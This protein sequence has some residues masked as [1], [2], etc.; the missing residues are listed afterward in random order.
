MSAQEEA[1]V[2]LREVIDAILSGSGQLEAQLRKCQFASQLVS[3]PTAVEWFRHELTGYDEPSSVP[4]YRKVM[5]QS[6]WRVKGLDEA[7]N[8]AVREAQHG[9]QYFDRQLETTVRDLVGPIQGISTLATKGWESGGLSFKNEI[10]NGVS[11]RLERIERIGSSAYAQVVANVER[12]AFD[13]A[14]SNY[15]LLKYGNALADIWQEQRQLVEQALRDLGL[16]QHLDAIEHGL[17]S[18]NP[19]QWRAAVY[20]C[21]SLMTDLADR[22]WR[23]P[24]DTYEHLPGSGSRSKLDVTREKSSNRLA[25]YL[26]QKGLQGRSGK[27]IRD[28][29]ERLATSI[30]SVISAEGTAHAPV[31]RADARLIAISA[32]I[33]VAELVARTDLAPVEHYEAPATLD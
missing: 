33:L 4:I 18:A 20:G 5:G 23:D 6:E 28:E 26:H 21:R 13:F 15:H 22:L 25:A 27:L 14:T 3:W 12:M 24:R 8:L 17:T 19:A 9:G 10:I 7:L 31:T 32:Y 1:V 16:I 11:V 29:M 30:R 2:L